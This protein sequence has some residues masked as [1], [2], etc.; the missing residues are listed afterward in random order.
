MRTL[1]LATASRAGPGRHAVCAAA[2]RWEDG[3][4][5]RVVIRRLRGGDPV[6]PAYR[7]VLLALG[8]ARRLRAR[9]VV[10][11]VD[12]ADV[13]AQIAGRSAVPVQALGGYLQVRAL[14]N[15]FR[16]AEI[17]YLTPACD[18]DAA[19]AASR[20]GARARSGQ[21]SC[22]DLPLWAAAS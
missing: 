12:D 18:P 7:A 6:P 1:R 16:S 8:E 4:G 10:V 5:R 15:V 2:L 17:L 21:P 9:A 22:T 11:G 13:A 20:V 3:A 14:L 19:A